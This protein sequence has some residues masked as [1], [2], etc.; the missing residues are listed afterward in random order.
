MVVVNEREVGLLPEP[1]GG[2]WMRIWMSFSEWSAFCSA[3]EA[4]NTG[5]EVQ[6]DYSEESA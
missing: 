5:T 4:A 3:P 2:S 6:E 1:G